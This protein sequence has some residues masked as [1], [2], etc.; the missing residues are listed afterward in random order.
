MPFENF[1]FILQVVTATYLCLPLLPPQLLLN[2]N[3]LYTLS[4]F[5]IIIPHSYMDFLILYIYPSIELL[6]PLPTFLFRL[7]R[8]LLSFI[9]SNFS[10]VIKLLLR[11]QV[12]YDNTF[13]PSFFFN[14][15]SSFYSIPYF[16]RT[17]LF[18]PCH[19]RSTFVPS[20]SLFI[21]Y[22]PAFV[23]Y[24]LHTFSIT[25][26]LIFPRFSISNMHMYS[27]LSI[28][29]ASR[30]PWPSPSFLF[31][32][33]LLN[34]TKPCV[35]TIHTVLYVSFVFFRYNANNP[36]HF[37]LPLSVNVADHNINLFAEFRFIALISVYCYEKNGFST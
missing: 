6:L 2:G 31:Y 4:N 32:I 27:R 16:R 30:R 29:S 14:V 28:C 33:I 22:R 26:I 12:F 10:V 36:R 8:I 37:P 34:H 11:V 35:S 21:N 1:S 5:S 24:Y 17:F 19:S 20:I 9:S 7:V 23:H 18:C 13:W 25:V 3:L 15:S